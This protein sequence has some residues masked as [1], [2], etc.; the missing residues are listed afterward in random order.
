V[1]RH[2]VICL[3]GQLTSVRC[4]YRSYYY[5]IL[6]KV[7]IV[8]LSIELWLMFFAQDFSFASQ[9]R[10]KNQKKKKKKKEEKGNNGF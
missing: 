8:V 3:E 7:P 4:R 10:G 2:H 9:N 5:T 1:P 6:S